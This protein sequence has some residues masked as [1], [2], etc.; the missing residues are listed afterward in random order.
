MRNKNFY[1]YYY[2]KINKSGSSFKN[3][4]FKIDF[5]GIGYQNEWLS[6]KIARGREKWGSGENI[7]LALSHDS[8]AYDYIALRSN[9]GKIRVKYIHG[10]L[11][12]NPV[13][14]NRYIT[15]RGIE[16]NNNKS[17]ILGLSETVIYSGENR[18]LEFAYINPISSHLEIELNDRLTRI[19]TASANGVWQFH[20]DMLISNRIRFSLNYLYDEFVLDKN[21]EVNKENGRAYSFR[22]SYIAYE[23]KRHFLSFYSQNI[24]IGTPVF[25]HFSGNNNFI[26][27]ESPLGWHRGSDTK[28]YSLGF[29]FS[30]I[31]SFITSFDFGMTY[32]GDENILNRPYDAYKDYIKDSFPSGIIKK[33]KFFNFNFDWWV[34]KNISLKVKINK[35]HE[36]NIM[37]GLYILP[38]FKIF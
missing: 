8:K 19:G 12:N 28:E 13:D 4:I 9:Y 5:S 34:R 6:F 37:F 31:N 23:N 24:L 22:I 17:L 14:I 27:H 36:K 26:Q 7:E 15:A 25:R 29:N 16:W 18:L 2:A 32:S 1:A 30:N 20:S 35:Y 3:A 11:E 21:I 33:N 38:N 10:F